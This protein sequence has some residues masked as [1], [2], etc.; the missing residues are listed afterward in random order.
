MTSS[1]HKQSLLIVSYHRSDYIHSIF[2]PRKSEVGPFDLA[3]GFAVFPEHDTFDV[4]FSQIVT[5]AFKWP[6]LNMDDFSVF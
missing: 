4:M 2:R 3:S 1:S 5:N 6:I